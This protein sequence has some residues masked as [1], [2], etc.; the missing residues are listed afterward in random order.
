VSIREQTAT[1]AGRLVKAT[2]EAVAETA[3]FIEYYTDPLCSW[4]WAFEAMWRRLRFE[5]S[6]HI[7]W[8]YHM[9][10]LIANWQ[11]YNDPFNDIRSPAQ[12]G[13]QWF[14]VH[15]ISGMPLDDR[16][17]QIDP[18]ASS[19]PACIAVKAAERQGQAAAEGYLRR[20][21]EAAMLER[22][23][24]ARQDVLLAIA[25][26][27]AGDSTSD[28][29]LDLDRFHADLVAPETMDAFRQ[30][31]R[32][33]AYYGIGR[34]PTLILHRF[35]GPGLMLVGYRPYDLLL[36]ALEHLAPDLCRGPERSPE[37]L[38]VAY[39]TYWQRVTVRELAEVLG[40]DIGQVSVLLKSLIAR[41]KLEQAGNSQ[42]EASIF[43]PI[44]QR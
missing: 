4:S 28:N 29:S 32:D 13:P 31:L 11:S 15:E 17:W 6:G 2:E 25:Q 21:R 23:N 35:D 16:L 14:Q 38:A 18:P 7:S 41:G 37:D 1:I 27:M 26:E 19:Y 24:I 39:V 42:S 3:V 8:R 36:A 20:L 12:M 40:D 43:V 34:F 33:A 9:G 30:N 10:G 44:P 22:R 5:Y